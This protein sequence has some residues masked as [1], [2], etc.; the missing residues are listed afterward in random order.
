MIRVMRNALRTLGALS[1]CAAC[2]GLE[3]APAHDD[4][5]ESIDPVEL[6]AD[7]PRDPD[8][9]EREFDG[10]VLDASEAHL[11]RPGD[12]LVV[13][14]R[15]LVVPAPGRGVSM[16]VEQDKGPAYTVTLAHLPSGELRLFDSRDPASVPLAMDPGESH[17]AMDERLSPACRDNAFSVDGNKWNKPYEWWFRAGMTPSGLT[18]ANTENILKNAAARLVNLSN[19][20]NISTGCSARQ[21]YKGRTS[22]GANMVLVNGAVGCGNGD[23]VNVHTF[24]GLDGGTLGL[25]C[26]YFYA[27]SK[28]QLGEY[29]EADVRYRRNAKWSTALT[30]PSTCRGTFFLSGVAVHEFGHVF[31]LG[32]VAEAGHAYLTM[33]TTSSPCNNGAA[34]LGQGDISAMRSLY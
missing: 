4:G 18:V 13:G 7:A 3:P 24:G 28:G 25:A 6:E 12:V 27:G 32:H 21:G 15:P 16:S 19:D 26:S 2:G 9:V 34:T 10:T 14:G 1:L 17:G 33:S 8:E 31:G 22:R 20:C 23:N 29:V 5:F 11:A 30:V